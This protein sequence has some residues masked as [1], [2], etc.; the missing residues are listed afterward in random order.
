MSENK[1]TNKQKIDKGIFTV[2]AF[3]KVYKVFHEG[4][5]VNLAVKTLRSELR[6]GPA[7]YPSSGD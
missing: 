5:G 3:G 1:L 7:G 2:E 6:E 4:W